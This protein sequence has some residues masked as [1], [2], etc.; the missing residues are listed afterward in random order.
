MHHGIYH[1]DTVASSSSHA[2]SMAAHPTL[3]TWGDSG[4]AGKTAKSP[5]SSAAGARCI[6]C[7]EVWLSPAS[8]LQV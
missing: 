4:W 5:V 7:R 1:Q 6:D 8:F 2:G 3:C